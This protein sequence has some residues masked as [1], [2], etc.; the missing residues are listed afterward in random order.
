[1]SAGEK[2]EHTLA[3]IPIQLVK[4]LK[5]GLLFYEVEINLKVLSKRFFITF[6]TTF[7]CV[8]SAINAGII[9]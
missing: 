3:Q 5:V 6:K 4:I 8:F 2:A 9:L 1:M 7:V